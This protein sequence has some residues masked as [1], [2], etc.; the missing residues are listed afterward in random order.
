VSIIEIENLTGVD[1]LPKLDGEV[2][3]RAVASKLWPRN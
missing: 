1:R 3:K 2:L